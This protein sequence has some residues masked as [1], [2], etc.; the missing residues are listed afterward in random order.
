V[1][2]YVV[3]YGATAAVFLVAD[4]LWLGVVA[5]DYYRDQL[6]AWLL[7]QPNLWAAA[8]FY[9]IYIA[10][11]VVL[12]IHPALRI[13]NWWIA[14]LNGAV[15]GLAAYA[16]YDLTNLATLRGWPAGLAAVDIGWGIFLTAL[17]ATAGY[18]VARQFA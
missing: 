14:F 18:A 13:G 16:A 11:I 1:L 9:L 4:M 17:S 12:C 2:G 6:G 10:G 3:A 7:D 5:R 15:L 8:A